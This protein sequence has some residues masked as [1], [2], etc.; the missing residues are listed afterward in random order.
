MVSVKAIAI[1]PVIGQR[2]ASPHPVGSKELSR[3]RYSFAFCGRALN[4]PHRRYRLSVRHLGNLEPHPQLSPTDVSVTSAS[5][6]AAGQLPRAGQRIETLEAQRDP[7]GCAAATSEHH[8]PS[9]AR[10]SSGAAISTRTSASQIDDL[11]A[12]TPVQLRRTHHIP[13]LFIDEIGPA[14]TSLSA[15]PL[16]PVHHRDLVGE[17]LPTLHG[18]TGVVSLIGHEPELA[19]GS[20]A[21]DSHDRR[22][23][24]L[25]PQRQV[26]GRSRLR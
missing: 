17:H 12:G 5:R 18:Q 8:N 3:H 20:G 11:H 19:A 23:D 14:S 24:R 21:H 16:L 22:T 2:F 15:P 25:D 7:A 26:T 9:M 4:Q 10:S 13:H 1:S 6:T